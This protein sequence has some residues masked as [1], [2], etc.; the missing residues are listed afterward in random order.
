MM[1]NSHMTTYTK[2][3][4]ERAV[5]KAIGLL[6]FNEIR[7]QLAA[8]AVS[9]EAKHLALTLRQKPNLE[10]V[11]ASLAEIEEA[12][13]IT[14]SGSLPPL[15]NQISM[16][17][18]LSMME[19]GMVLSPILLTGAGSFLSDANKLKRF[20]LAKEETAP[21]LAS[22]GAS[23]KDLS[24][25]QEEIA[26][27]ISHDMVLDQ[28]SPDLAKVRKRRWLVE[29]KI[30]DKLDKL[31]KQPGYQHMLQDQLIAQRGG[32]YVIPVKAQHKKHIEGQVHDRSASGST[33]FIEPEEVKRLHDELNKLMAEEEQICYRI[34]SEL[35]NAIDGQR[36]AI[37]IMLEVM[38]YCD[39]TFARARLAK[40]QEA[41]RPKLSAE[42]GFRLV[43]ARHPLL[44]GQAVPMSLELHRK[45]RGL[46]IT[47]P[48]TGGKTVSMKTAG[49]LCYM[50]LCGLFIPA[51][52]GTIV[53]WTKQILADIGDG[54]SISQ[55]LST[56]SAHM[57][58]IADILAAADDSSLILLDEI[59]SGTDPKE[60]MGIAIAILEALYE[61]GSIIIASTHYG[62]I[63]SFGENHPGFVNGAMGFDI[64]TLKPLYKLTV[65]KSG[66]SNGILIAKR[67]GM[68]DLIVNRALAIAG[69]ETEAFNRQ[70]V[71]YE[72]AI[73]EKRTAEETKE[74]V[75]AVT[76]DRPSLISPDQA[77]EKERTKEAFLVGDMV[78]VPYLNLMGRVTEKANH[79][80]ELEIEVKGKRLKV[81]Q[82][83]VALY[84][85]KDELYPENY[86]MEV[87][88]K[89]K[90][91]RKK[92]KLINKGKGKGLVIDC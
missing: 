73:E 18:A 22:Y 11:S 69:A 84:I 25:L 31:I 7:V 64:E 90:D 57:T 80:G 5:E 26:A 27:C 44:G 45:K 62:E 49:L 17:Q 15:N 50:A 13:S 79:K 14:K 48:N 54:Q 39:F 12:L 28:A 85:A 91:Y 35:T 74:P 23:L 10:A 29:D 51:G 4:N 71:A 47:G 77:K 72:A 42:I 52:E 46:I 3:A 58:N 89:S 60:G 82:R 6:E 61:K 53:G 30:K 36:Q 41:I 65:G 67:L 34:Q 86:D 40:H 87:V 43:E 83:R 24:E 33:I 37:S 76:E 1:M 75:L 21:M 55:N 68:P 9:E 38:T 63:K 66:E 70:V 88:L 56:F 16:R 8:L 32:R 78:K 81:D 2:P 19:R 20:L 59:G 92:S